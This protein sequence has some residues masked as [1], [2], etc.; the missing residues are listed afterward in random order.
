[1]SSIEEAYIFPQR[2]FKNERDMRRYRK[3]IYNVKRVYPYAKMAGKKFREVDAAMAKLKTEKQQKEYIKKVEAEIKEQ[4]EGELKKLT[5]TQ[6]RIL[7]K[8]IDRETGHTSYEL[9]KELRGSFQAFL[10]Q[11]LARLFGSNLKSEFD[12][13]GE[14]KLMNEIVVMIERGAL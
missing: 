1:M 8:L 12:P 4:Y 7:I 6:G 10:W 9:V 2:K 5:V 13:K 11:S 3:M 14:D